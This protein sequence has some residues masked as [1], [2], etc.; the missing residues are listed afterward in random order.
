MFPK[1]QLN[2]KE[3]PVESVKHDLTEKQQKITDE[4]LM[5]LIKN[6][7][8]EIEIIKCIESGANVHKKYENDNTL[9]HMVCRK[10]ISIELIQLLLKLKLDINEKNISG[11]TPLHV[12]CS[13]NVNINAIQFLI[14]SNADVKSENNF[15]E[16]DK[17]TLKVM[18]KMLRKV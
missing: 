14:D 8:D 2:V 5:L 1:F 13:N 12:A 18:A 6:E 7:A 3:P 11:N 10:N 9:L 15:K 4:I 17:K 16:E